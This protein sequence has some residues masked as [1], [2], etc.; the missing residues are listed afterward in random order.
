MKI[1][2]DISE[3]YENITEIPKSGSRKYF[4]DGAIIQK[5]LGLVG[6]YFPAYDAELLVEKG[7]VKYITSFDGY[8]RIPDSVVFEVNDCS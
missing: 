2:I 5:A 4:D 7:Y 6:D 1:I 8:F 3:L